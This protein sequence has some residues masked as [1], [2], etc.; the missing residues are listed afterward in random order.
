[1]QDHKEVIQKALHSMQ[2]VGWGGG[3]I[4]MVTPMDVTTTGLGTFD[5]EIPQE[6]EIW[7]KYF[8]LHGF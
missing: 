6:I 7:L 5:L 8:E 3:T 1:M 2:K 4:K